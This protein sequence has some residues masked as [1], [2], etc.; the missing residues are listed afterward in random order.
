MLMMYGMAGVARVFSSRVKL[1]D[2]FFSA[3][4]KIGIYAELK[5]FLAIFSS[6]VI[7]FMLC[8]FERKIRHF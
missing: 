3:G 4:L 7:I 8:F 6:V 5:I 1:K 2:Y